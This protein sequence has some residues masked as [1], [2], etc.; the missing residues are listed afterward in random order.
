MFLG[1]GEGL[2]LPTRPLGQTQ[3]HLKFSNRGSGVQTRS[4]PIGTAHLIVYRGFI[5]KMCLS[6]FI[7]L[8]FAN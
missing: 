4:L 5:E 3:F 1:R 8:Y 7:Y 2:L 6:S